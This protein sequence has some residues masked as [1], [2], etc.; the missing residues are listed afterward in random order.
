[1]AYYRCLQS[2]GGSGPTLNKIKYFSGKIDNQTGTIT[3]DSD[4]IYT[5]WIPWANGDFIFDIGFTTTT[6]GTAVTVYKDDKTYIDYW[7]PNTRFR[8]IN[9]RPNYS[10]GGRWCRISG[11]L[12]NF[13]DILLINKADSVLYCACEPYQISNS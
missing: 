5:D 7:T 4:Y 12:S 6:T 10:S 3:A 1:M 9:G 2:N 8:S 11:P 13:N